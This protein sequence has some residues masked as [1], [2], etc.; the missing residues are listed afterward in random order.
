MGKYDQTKHLKKTKARTLHKCNT[1]NGKIDAGEYYYVETQKDKFLHSLHAKRFC[2]KC[3]EKHGDRL[4]IIEREKEQ[5]ELDKSK[6][7]A[8]YL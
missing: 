6:S 3:Y 5:R 1:C 2:F 4:L 8:N 7:L